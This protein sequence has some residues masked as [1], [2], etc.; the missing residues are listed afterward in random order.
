MNMREQGL[1]KEKPKVGRPK[2]S[3]YLDRDLFLQ[4]ATAIYRELMSE[5]K[6][7]TQWDVAERIH[8]SR[9]T[10]NRYLKTYGVTWMQIRKGPMQE[11]WETERSDITR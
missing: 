7:P 2:G 8:V 4:R 5:N 11:V 3:T 10:F 6:R 9:P 1:Q